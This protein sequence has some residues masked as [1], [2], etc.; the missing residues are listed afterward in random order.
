M[1]EAKKIILPIKRDSLELSY[2]DIGSGER[3][4]IF[5]H[6]I[7]GS[8]RS[9]EHVANSVLSKQMRIV[10]PDLPGFGES[11]PPINNEFDLTIQAGILVH[12]FNA[13]RLNKVIVFGHSLGG[14]LAT[15]LLR[16]IPDRILAMI[17]SE[18]NLT[19][20]DCGE[21][22]NVCET[23]FEDF[24]RFKYPELKKKGVSAS[25][26]AFYGTA[27]SVVEFAKS[28]LLLNILETSQ[29][30]VLFIRGSDS[31]F[32]TE[33][34]GENIKNVLLPDQTHSSLAKSAAVLEA[35]QTFLLE[36]AIINRFN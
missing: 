28:E 15:L 35:V 1:L 16:A 17:S 11:A 33:P 8:K 18:G 12:L 23:T 25:P 13:L 24:L 30:P 26:E 9:F 19:L 34:V 4:I 3:S 36:K 31:H 5:L 10:I 6:G 27:T 14:M 32:S 20:Q 29:I 21:S 7:Q 22:R 2:W